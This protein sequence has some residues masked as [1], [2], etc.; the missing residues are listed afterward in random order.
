MEFSQAIQRAS[1]T[2][3]EPH[4]GDTF[5]TLLAERDALLKGPGNIED[6]ESINRRLFTLSNQ[7][8]KLQARMIEHKH[9]LALGYG[10]LEAIKDA[11]EQNFGEYSTEELSSGNN[12]NFFLNIEGEP[13][14]LV[15]RVEDRATLQDEADLQSHPVSEYFS[16]DYATMMLPFKNESG[17]VGY[18]PVV[19]SQ[20]ASGGNLSHFAESLADRTSDEKGETAQACFSQLS[21]FLIKLQDS[22]HYHPDIKLS[23]F[24]YDNGK[25][26]CADRKTFLNTEQASP[27]KILTTINLAP[28]EF[29]ETVNYNPK[30]NAVTPKVKH[31]NTKLDMPSFMQYQ[32][33]AAINEYL[34]DSDAFDDNPLSNQ[35]QNLF[36]LQ[37]ELIRENPSDRLNLKDFNQLL[38]QLDTTPDVFLT[39]LEKLHPSVSEDAN[40]LE[41]LLKG[42]L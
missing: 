34:A 23:N 24:L 31:R 1:N 16:E 33:G 14:P 7:D 26:F 4:Q 8:E 19:L 39:E 22:G 35:V 6:F 12:T 28:P 27:N 20:F 2:T 17:E 41:Q 5:Y 13:N 36:I 11:V 10:K 38:T 18:Q 15:I 25:V 37:T 30:T 3:E 9:F 29:L 21:D 42:N 32:V 40:D